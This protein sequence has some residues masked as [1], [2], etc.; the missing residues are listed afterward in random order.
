MV[1]LWFYQACNAA[2]CVLSCCGS[3]R[4]C[5]VCMYR[6]N[7]CI[8]EVTMSCPLAAYSKSIWYTIIIMIKSSGLYCCDIDMPP[9]DNYC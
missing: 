5:N 9:I 8:M 3:D 7:N 6:L 2:K 4:A 1:E